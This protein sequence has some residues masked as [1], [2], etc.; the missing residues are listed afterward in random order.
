[1]AVAGSP[2]SPGG[3]PDPERV[4][5]ARAAITGDAEGCAAFAEPARAAL[6][7]LNSHTLAR[8][9]DGDLGECIVLLAHVRDRIGALDPA[10][11][12]PRRGLG[13]L[14]DSRGGRLKAFRAAW[15]AAAAVSTDAA[16]DLAGRGGAIATRSVALDN[17]W[18]ET[19][20][21]I[22]ALDAD[23]AAARNWLAESSVLP[24]TESAPEDALNGGVEAQADAEAAQAT[25]PI[26][27]GDA[28]NSVMAIQTEGIAADPGVVALPHPLETRLTALAAVRT[29]ALGRLP[30]LRA[31][32]N[33]D[34]RVPGLLSDVCEGIEAWRA[35]WRD[36]LGLAGRKPKKVRPD[37]HRLIEARSA[38]ADRIAAAERELS[39][40]QERRAELEARSTPPGSARMAA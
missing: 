17:L 21:A 14:F 12:Q 39:A 35:D 33:A 19:R 38:L 7:S 28:S 30:L 40:A 15:T 13:G 11:L 31:T 27:A 3:A 37:A 18:A 5:T 36:A 34:C 8:T 26:E 25:V 23:I 29:V 24:V 2:I 20:D 16:A 10:R 4:S 32:Q 22:A 6:V 9:R 1:M